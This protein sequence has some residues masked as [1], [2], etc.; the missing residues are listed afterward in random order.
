MMNQNERDAWAEASAECYWRL[1]E[2]MDQ[3]TEIKVAEMTPREFKAWLEGF[4]ESF[5]GRPTKKQWDKVKERLE[6]VQDGDRNCW[7][8]GDLH[9]PWWP[10]WWTYTVSSGEGLNNLVGGTSIMANNSN[11]VYGDAAETVYC[12]NAVEI[13]REE[14]ARL[15]T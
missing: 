2:Q 1:E 10:T 7:Y 4:E 15:A 3:I 11:A 14:G 5:N 6:M 9:R 12:F 8:H 13:G